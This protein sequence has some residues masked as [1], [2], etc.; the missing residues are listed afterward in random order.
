MTLTPTILWIAIAIGAAA[1]ALVAHAL[2]KKALKEEEDYFLQDMANDETIEAYVRR[3][4][5]YNP[6]MWVPP[7]FRSL[8]AE[9]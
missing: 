2:H 3:K 8:D 6:H 1:V 7:R 5:L 9:D 4:R